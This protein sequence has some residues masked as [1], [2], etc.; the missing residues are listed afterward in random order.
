M[1]L[2]FGLE[3]PELE[4]KSTWSFVFEDSAL[5]LRKG[6]SSGKATPNEETQVSK[7]KFV[8]SNF[9]PNC[10]AMMATDFE[11]PSMSAEANTVQFQIA[12][13]STARKIVH[14]GYRYVKFNLRRLVTQARRMMRRW[15]SKKQAATVRAVVRAIGKK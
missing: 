14:T 6:W 11:I 8:A 15:N 2:F 10:V 9:S 7:S 12:E 13:Q 5:A 3:T 4:S 1:D